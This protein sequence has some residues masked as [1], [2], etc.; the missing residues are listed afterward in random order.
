MKTINIDDAS[1][2]WWIPRQEKDSLV[3]MVGKEERK[4]SL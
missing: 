1:P 3:S 4:E 2:F